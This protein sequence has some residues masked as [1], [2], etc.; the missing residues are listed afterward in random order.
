MSHCTCNN[1]QSRATCNGDMCPNITVCKNCGRLPP[2]EEKQVNNNTDNLIKP[3]VYIDVSEVDEQT[4][5]KLIEV[6]DEY[7][8]GPWGDMDYSE[9][10]RW[11]WL[12]VDEGMDYLLGNRTLTSHLDITELTIEQILGNDYKNQSQDKSDINEERNMVNEIDCSRPQD[13]TYSGKNIVHIWQKP[14]SVDYLIA[15]DCGNNVLGNAWAVGAEIIKKP[16]FKPEVGKWYQFSDNTGYQHNVIQQYIGFGNG[17]FP[18]KAGN[19]AMYEYCRPIPQAIK[20]MMVF[21]EE[22]EGE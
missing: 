21:S 3:G 18:H 16:Q 7:C 19:G 15:Y 2:K 9:V 14:S 12:I 22:K 11:P 5:D 20:E 13:Y 4:F 1:Y 8:N 17:S 10:S 6:F